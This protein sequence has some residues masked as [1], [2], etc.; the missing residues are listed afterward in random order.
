[1]EENK[2]DHLQIENMEEIS[3]MNGKYLTFWTAGQLFG[4]P[5]ADVVQ[6]VGMQEI[7]SMPEFPPYAK[8]IMNLRGSI[9]PVIDVRLRFN[10]P[11]NEY[12]ERTC[13]VVTN[14]KNA[15]IGFI[16]DEVDEVIKIDEEQISKPPQVS[17]ERSEAHTNLSGIGKLEKKIVLLINTETMLSDDTFDFLTT[18]S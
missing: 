7:T 2:M 1:M 11:E 8:G 3:E 15:L 6:I 13:I 4:I 14:I 9:I 17:S 5:I 18:A 12:N 16:V 10:K